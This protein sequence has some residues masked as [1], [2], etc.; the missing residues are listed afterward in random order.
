MIGRIPKKVTKRLAPEILHVEDPY[1]IFP[2]LTS[3]PKFKLSQSD[4]V[5][6]ASW[7][8]LA[9][10]LKATLLPTLLCR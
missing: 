9:D 6:L 7:E 3:D 2:I 8:G 1:S 5:Y 10:F 4:Y